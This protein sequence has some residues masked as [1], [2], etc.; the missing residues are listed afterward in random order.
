VSDDGGAD[1]P[2]AVI[3]VGARRAKQSSKAADRSVHSTALLVVVENVDYGFPL[4]CT[5]LPV[6]YVLAHAGCRLSLRVIEG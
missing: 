5:L 2:V 6:H 4:A 3:C 1:N